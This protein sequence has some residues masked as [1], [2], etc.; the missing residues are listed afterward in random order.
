[1]DRIV[2]DSYPYRKI[3]AERTAP[4]KIF[5]KAGEASQRVARKDTAEVPNDVAF[6]IILG[7]LDQD[8]GQAVA[9]HSSCM[10]QVR[11]GFRSSQL[12]AWSQAQKGPLSRVRH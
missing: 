7:W 10:G 12:C 4:F 9:R 1:L 5:G 11:H 8:D 6:V 2:E 3:V